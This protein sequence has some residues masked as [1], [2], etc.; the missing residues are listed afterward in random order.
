MMK[1]NKKSNLDERQEQILLKIEH[2]ACWIA[3]WGLLIAIMAQQFVYGPE[4]RAIAGEWIVFLVLSVY[5]LAG[6]L[7]N[8]IWDRKLQPTVRT[9]L[10]ASVIAAVA[11]G[12]F[13]FFSVFFR[14]RDKVAG[15]AAAGVISAVSMF[16][17]TFL[18]LSL[19]LRAYNKRKAALEAE[20]E[21]SDEE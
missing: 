21:D 18:A 4:L 3:F 8:G 12:V 13:M 15:A 6:C 16:V 7:K 10:I 19:V 17:C 11:V 9:N 1:M 5:I 2:N 14:Y 20:P